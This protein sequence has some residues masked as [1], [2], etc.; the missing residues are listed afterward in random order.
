METIILN[1]MALH[2]EENLFD[3]AGYFPGQG[4]GDA[5]NRQRYTAFRKLASINDS[6]VIG[7]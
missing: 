5:T 6:G 3:Q 2:G 7:S 1:Y 4:L